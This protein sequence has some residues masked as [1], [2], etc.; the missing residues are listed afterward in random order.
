LLNQSGIG[1]ASIA[2]PASVNA[3]QFNYFDG[4]SLTEAMRIDGSGNLGIGTDSPNQMLELSANNGS[5]VANVLRFNDADTGVSAGQTTG[6]IEFAENDG[7]D[8]TVSAF[9]EVETVTTAGGGIMTFGTGA[10]G[11]TADEKMRIDSSGSVGIGTSSPVGRLSVI[12][13]D[14]TTQAVFG[15]ATGTTGRG[16]RIALAQRGGTFNLDAILDAQATVGVAGNLVFQT[17]S[18]ERMRI[19]SS[20]RVTMPY[21]PAFLAQPS[22]N[23]ANIAINENVDIALGT[24]IF[25]QGANFASS[26]FTAPVTGKYQLQ[27][28]VRLEDLDA[29]ANYYHLN[30]ETSNR[31]YYNIIDPDF[32]QDAA[33][34]TLVITV[35]ADMDA[36]DTAKL[37]ILQ[38]SGT[39][40]TDIHAGFTTFSG[41]LVA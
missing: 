33:Y 17:Q 28:N 14:N 13:T 10:A 6:R 18:I 12:G 20:G 29:A 25:D 32:G 38:S 1:A 34:W 19:D 36:S 31:A 30:I 5:G 24:E 39:S 41:Y 23:Q 2:V 9:L 11:V 40:Q 21:Q 26:T 7:G 37:S 27:A 16:L 4:S 35:L 22:S 3:L 8:T 15:G